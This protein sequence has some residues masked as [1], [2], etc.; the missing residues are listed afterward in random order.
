MHLV[1]T[2]QWFTELST[3]SEVAIDGDFFCYGLEPPN[4]SYKPCCIP[5]DTYQLELLPSHRFQMLTP[6]VM[7]VA[8][9]E[10]VELHPGNYPTDTEGCLL[11]GLTR[12]E[13]F[14]GESRDAFM[15]LM[16]KLG[17]ENGIVQITYVGGVEA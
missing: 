10:G 17:R 14:V 12:E 15:E 11:V 2:R 7:D 8:G 4:R 13:D 5:P 1:V 16:E 6:H 3:G 9:F